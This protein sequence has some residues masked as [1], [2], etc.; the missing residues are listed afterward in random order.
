M[1]RRVAAS[2]IIGLVLL[3]ALA[4]AHARVSPAVSLSGQ[5]QLYTLAVP[6][7]K[8][9]ALTTKV[10]LSL[11]PGFSIDSFA[12]S[13][14]WRRSLA[15][16]GSGDNAVVQQVTWS[17]GQVPTGDDSVFSFLAQ[18]AHPGVIRFTVQQTYSDG[19]IVNWNGPESSDAPAPTIQA[20]SALGG[21]TGG[22]SA[23][24]DVIAIVVSV[25]AILAAGV[26]IAERRGPG[27]PLA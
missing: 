10:A 22:G 18:P 25:I 1:I 14:G 9:G 6:T 4:S 16:S 5:L 11:P 24:L 20:V 26:A 3:P 23:T 8:S 7:E 15:Q 17:G 21:G 12:P 19:S 27:R 13:P 2:S